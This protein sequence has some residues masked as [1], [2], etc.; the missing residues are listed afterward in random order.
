[1]EPNKTFFLFLFQSFYYDDVLNVSFVIPLSFSVPFCYSGFPDEKLMNN[2]CTFKVSFNFGK[3]DLKNLKSKIFVRML[4]I[5]L[6]T[7][8]LHRKRSFTI[9]NN[10]FE[11]KSKEECKLLP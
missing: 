10:D 7:S 8:S 2:N 6:S 1:M 4:S 5:V 9:C 3:F 11:S